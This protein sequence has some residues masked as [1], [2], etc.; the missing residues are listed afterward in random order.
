[1]FVRWFAGS[2]VRCLP[3]VGLRCVWIRCFFSGGFEPNL[4]DEGWYGRG[5]LV[6]RVSSTTV[7]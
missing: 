7:E 4:A 3:S 1:M 6:L 5:P 2:L